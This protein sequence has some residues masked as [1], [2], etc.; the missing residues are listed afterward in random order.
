MLIAPK[1]MTFQKLKKKRVVH[2]PFIII[3]AVIMVKFCIGIML[4]KWTK[5]GIR[6]AF[7]LKLRMYQKFSKTGQ[8]TNASFIL[9]ESEEE[10][11]CQLDSSL[12]PFFLARA[13][14]EGVVKSGCRIYP[15]V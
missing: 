8:K 11:H 9:K 6:K 5:T 14:G 15:Q 7:R 1:M 2:L 13:V 4:H 12:S 10:T 3:T